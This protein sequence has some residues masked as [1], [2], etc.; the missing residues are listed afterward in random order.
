M[1]DTV[2]NEQMAPLDMNSYTVPEERQNAFA[3]NNFLFQR[4]FSVFRYE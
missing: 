4:C 2:L 1:A 3:W